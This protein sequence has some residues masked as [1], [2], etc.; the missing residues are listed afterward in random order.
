MKQEVKAHREAEAPCE[1][2]GGRMWYHR[3]HD[4]T[5]YC[6][7]WQDYTAW[8]KCECGNTRRLDV[9]DGDYRLYMAQD[10]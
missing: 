5:R 6:S 10:N 1:K 8:Y 9:Y 3:R 7:G 2:C 4:G